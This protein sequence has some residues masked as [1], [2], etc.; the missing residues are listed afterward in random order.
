MK[1]GKRD[2]KMVIAVIMIMGVHLVTHI[3]VPIHDDVA[4][5]RK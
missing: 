3:A 1:A 5:C 2:V 4:A